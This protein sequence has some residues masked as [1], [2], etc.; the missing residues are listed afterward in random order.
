MDLTTPVAIPG[1][2]QFEHDVATI[3]TVLQKRSQLSPDKVAFTFLATGEEETGSMTYRE[4][5]SKARTTAAKLVKLGLKGK[6]VLM[7]YPPGLDF[8]T[9]FFGCLYAGTIPATAYPPRKNRSV[10]RVRTIAEDCGAK[11]ILTTAAISRSLERNFAEDSLLSQ[12]EWHATD[13][14]LPEDANS[15][16][17]PEPIFENL[18][19]LQ[20]TSGSTGDP[21]GVMVSHRNIMYNLR[22]L[23]LIFRITPEDIAVH[24][25]PQFHDLGLI[26]GILETVYSGSR[27][28]LIPPFTFI[29]N[30]FSLLHAITRY[31]AT[32][33]GQPDFA[34]NHCVE[35]ISELDRNRLDLSSLRVMYSGAEPVRKSTLDRFISAFGPVGLKP[36]SLIPAYG[37]AESTLILTGATNPRPTFFLPVIASELEMN[38]V[39]PVQDVNLS[40]DV[41]WV[42]SNG[43]PTMDTS[44]L[45]V[46]PETRAVMPPNK[47]GEIWACGS[48]VTMG[49]YGNQ[50]LSAE[51]FKAGLIGKSEGKWLR[52]GDLGFLFNEELFITGRQKDLIIING[53]NLYPHDM[54][55]MV[56]EC[57][58]AIR[59]TCV[60]AFPIEINGK[61]RLAIVAELRRSILPHDTARIIESIVTA[62]S[63]EFEVQPKRVAL[64]RAGSIIKT[65]SGKI[66]RSANRHALLDGKFDVIA[67]R[68]FDDH[69][70]VLPEIELSGPISLEHFI[71]NWI[72]VHLND[73]VPID[74][75]NTLSTY[76]IDSIK[77][78][79]LT[80]DTKEL[81]GFEWSP[82]LFF[83]EMSI[84]QLIAEGEKLIVEGVD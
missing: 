59:K 23:Q 82:S 56:E 27:A 50:P 41:Q 20:Y 19:F 75:A 65:S 26:F 13:E 73:G 37:M 11:S 62:V 2:L 40:D 1:D 77:A 14:W 31:R 4:L 79:E 25:V 39:V 43:K 51:Q 55:E 8:I 32:V 80:A 35:K 18:A 74:S 34:F 48:T 47:V 16:E 10:H 72:S 54:E 57:H 38:R 28:V 70:A 68:S 60:A 3:V 17:L 81:F 6:N 69:D 42:A 30:P 33:S 78:V 52:T 12:L 71:V 49:Y 15:S 83:E 36:E 61:E 46:D 67:E 63:R 76:G 24:W 84:A 64:I 21:K 29:S 58:S 7:F 44:V 53:R 9:A 45:I 22:S 66:M 5:D